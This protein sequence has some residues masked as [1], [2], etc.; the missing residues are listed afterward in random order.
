MLDTG[1][2]SC[3]SETLLVIRLYMFIWLF[4]WFV[5]VALGV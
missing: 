2:V 3:Y 5:R 1:F 4:I